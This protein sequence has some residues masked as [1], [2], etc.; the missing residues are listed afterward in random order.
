[1]CDIYLRAV[2][3]LLGATNNER[4][5]FYVQT[6]FSRK[7]NISYATVHDRIHRGEIALHLINGKV[8]INVEEA[9]KACEPRKRER[10][11]LKDL[12]AA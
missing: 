8:Q 5:T 3:A 11:I 2:L 9:L 12:F 4:T 6:F 7:Y 10:K 1:L